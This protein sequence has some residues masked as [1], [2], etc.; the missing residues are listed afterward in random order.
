MLLTPAQILENQNRLNLDGTS[1]FLTQGGRVSCLP[2]C[3]GARL[4]PHSLIISIYANLS[5][6]ADCV[7][8]QLRGD[9]VPLQWRNQ[10]CQNLE[11]GAGKRCSEC[12]A[13]RAWTAETEI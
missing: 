3:L 13:I 12:A 1:S 6:G 5:E 10:I 7:G 11:E 4:L 9:R 2:G 8:G